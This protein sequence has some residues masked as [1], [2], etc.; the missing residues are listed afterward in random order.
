MSSHFIVFTGSGDKTARA[1][2]AKTGVLKRSFKG[3]TY[4]INCLA[5]STTI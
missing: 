1:Y 2:D 3:H 4:A 5:V